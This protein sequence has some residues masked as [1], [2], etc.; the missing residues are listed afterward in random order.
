M[1]L[2][3]RNIMIV[4][5]NP[6]LSTATCCNTAAYHLGSEQQSINAV[7]YNITPLCSKNKAKLETCLSILKQAR[8]NIEKYPS[9]TNDNNIKSRL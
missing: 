7:L 4:L 9:V 6:V 1:E 5:Y 3:L 2:P 8:I